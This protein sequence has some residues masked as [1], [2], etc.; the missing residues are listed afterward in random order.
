[1]P[2]SPLPSKVISLPHAVRQELRQ[3]GLTAE[4]VREVA[5]AAIAGRNDAL[6]IDPAGTPGTLAYIFGVRAIRRSLL[7]RPGWRTAR[8][9]NV[10]STVND[11][12]GIQI[13]FQ[14]VDAACTDRDPQAISAK[15]PASRDL[16]RSG[17]QRELFA[18]TSVVTGTRRGTQP[19]VWMIC[20]SANGEVPR[21]E[22]SCPREFDGCNFDGFERRLFVDLEVE[23]VQDHRRYDDSGADVAFDVEVTRKQ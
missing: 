20:V 2:E 5:L 17:R 11:D 22:V 23:D 18:S 1:M 19:T 9:Q 21:A 12:L 3:I 4:I 14:N 13:V 6:Q 7:A 8:H 16:V 15:G 10:E